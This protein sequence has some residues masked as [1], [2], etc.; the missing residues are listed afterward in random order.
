MY[1]KRYTWL[2]M[3]RVGRCYYENNKMVYPSYFGFTK[4]V[5][6]IK[7]YMITRIAINYDGHNDK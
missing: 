6:Y 5:K 4:M 7:I 2:D 1:M 3:I